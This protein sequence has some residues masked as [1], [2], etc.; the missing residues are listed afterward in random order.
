MNTTL[1]P[2]LCICVIVFFD[3]IL[4]YSS[5]LEQPISHLCQVFELLAKDQWLIKLSKC[6][7]A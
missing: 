2:L 4:V 5:M 7:F 1:K 6:R 3:D